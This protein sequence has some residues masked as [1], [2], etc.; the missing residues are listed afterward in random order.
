MLGGRSRALIPWTLRDAES[1]DFE[2]LLALQEVSYRA[3]VEALWGP[4]NPPDQRR[5]FLTAFADPDLR[6]VEVGGVPIGS[7]TVRWDADPVEVASLQ[8]E[9]AHQD[10]G[11]GT[12]LLADVIT[13]ARARDQDVTLRVL[14]PNPAQA[15]YARLG[16]VE[17][18][19][20]DTHL[21]LRFDGSRAARAALRAAREPW[22]DPERRDGWA[23]DA[24]ASDPAPLVEWIRS[25]LVREGLPQPL[26]VLDVGDGAGG[27][28]S[29]WGSLAEE[30]TA[31]VAHPGLRQAARR[32]AA[33]L[34]H[35]TVA[36]AGLV[37]LDAPK[38]FDVVACLD[39]AWCRALTATARR[40]Q[41]EA[42]ARVL[43]PGGRLL[44]QAPNAPW[45]LRHGGDPVPVT[46][47]IHDVQLSRI[48]DHE[49]DFHDATRTQRDVFVVERDGTTLA[50]FEHTRVDALLGLPEIEAGLDDAGLTRV[51][52]FTDTARTTRG[53]CIG[54]DLLLLAGRVGGG[55]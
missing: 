39:G 55:Q 42:I 11:W 44:L 15:L 6:V 27:R 54:R 3:H 46:H 28:L 30:I 10:R 19:R 38:A 35:A 48:R 41:A 47:E 21:Y 18:D 16:F 51:E 5:R 22:S 24:C 32:R 36:E 17:I 26:H 53:R 50:E 37:E 33:R 4:W 14:R 34:P 2:R 23:Y 52:T 9:P 1:S 45:R 49:F 8:L 29:R 31:V 40:K 7:L 25:V 20:S 43:R 13:R 12:R